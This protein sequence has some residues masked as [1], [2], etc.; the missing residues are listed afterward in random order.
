MPW[1]VMFPGLGLLRVGQPGVDEGI[2]AIKRHVP[3]VNQKSITLL[4]VVGAATAK[5]KPCRPAGSI[6][7][8]VDWEMG[9]STC[10]KDSVVPLQPRTIVAV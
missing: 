3:S 6:A 8:R 4:S 9:M 2:G 10:W 1:Y 7:M 5:L